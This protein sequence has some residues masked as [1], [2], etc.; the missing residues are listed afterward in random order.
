MR[1]PCS[2]G[3]GGCRSPADVAVKV[4][5]IF[6]ISPFDP[7]QSFPARCVSPGRG[8]PEIGALVP[9]RPSHEGQTHGGA[10]RRRQGLTH[11]GGGGRPFA[12][13]HGRCQWPASRSRRRLVRGVLLNEQVAREAD[14][15]GYVGRLV[16]AASVK[17]MSRTKRNGPGAAPCHL[18]A[19]GD[20]PAACHPGPGC[21]GRRWRR[22]EDP[23][24]RADGSQFR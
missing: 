20:E 3:Y 11:G 6:D 1:R 8:N 5:D 16:D 7:F 12:N 9:G 14:R 19:R 10:W 21:G 17:Q 4:N 15:C 23:A 13:R 22:A 24:L 18:A 2:A